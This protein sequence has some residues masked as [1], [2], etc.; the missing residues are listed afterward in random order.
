MEA[1]EIRERERENSF[2][3]SVSKFHEFIKKNKK[4]FLEKKIQF[5]YSNTMNQKTG[6]QVSI[7]FPKTKLRKKK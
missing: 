7:Q 6:K 5:F 1:S 3:N 2:P 4:R